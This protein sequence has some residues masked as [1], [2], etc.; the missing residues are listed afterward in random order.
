MSAE[1]E[2]QYILKTEISAQLERWGFDARFYKDVKIEDRQL[3]VL[4][5]VESLLASP[6]SITALVGPRGLGKTTIAATLAKKAAWRNYHSKM[7][8]PG[9]PVI[10]SSFV[11]RKT[12]KLVARFK[13]LFA[14]FGSIQTDALLDSMDYL[15]RQYEVL[16]IDEVHDCDDQK[17]SRRVLTDLIDRRYSALRHTIL[18]SNQTASE[19][20]ASV[21]DSIMSR[22]NENGAVIECAWESF[23]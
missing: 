13:P 21:G 14:D 20:A 5:W 9:K 11:Y 16:A 2:R 1:E 15:A 3:K 7:Q 12:A 8:E 19:F 4:N 17:A 23:R 22:L 6:S 18:I 10:H